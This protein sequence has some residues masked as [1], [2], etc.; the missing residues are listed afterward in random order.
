[1]PKEVFFLTKQI[2]LKP[3]GMVLIVTNVSLHSNADD[4]ND[5]KSE[6]IDTKLAPLSS[7]SFVLPS[8]LI[9]LLTLL[10]VYMADW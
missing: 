8:P 3:F 2:M 9:I 5:E 1:M 6:N 10:L 4:K 7:S